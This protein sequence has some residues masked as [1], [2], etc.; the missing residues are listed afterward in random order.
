MI[1]TFETAPV[2]SFLDRATWFPLCEKARA[3]FFPM[4]FTASRYLLQG[5]SGARLIDPT[6]WSIGPRHDGNRA[7]WKLPVAKGL[8]APVA[9]SSTGAPL[10]ARGRVTKIAAISPWIAIFGRGLLHGRLGWKASLARAG[11]EA[12]SRTFSLGL[13][14]KT[15]IKH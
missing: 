4:Q 2:K 14:R 8:C 7:L 6:P 13:G 15:P 3:I 10:R 9:G 12:D 1:T 5:L 11:F